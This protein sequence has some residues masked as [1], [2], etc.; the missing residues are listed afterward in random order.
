VDA[1]GLPGPYALQAMGVAL[2]PSSQHA[3]ND[4]S[5]SSG[6]DRTESAMFNLTK[7]SARL[8]EELEC[9]KR[10]HDWTKAHDLVAEEI[11]GETRTVDIDKATKM[12]KEQYQRAL[13]EVRAAAVGSSDHINADKLEVTAAWQERQAAATHQQMVA[14]AKEGRDMAWQEGNSQPP[15]SSRAEPL[16]DFGDALDSDFDPDWFLTDEQRRE[17]TARDHAVDRG[18]LE[19]PAPMMEPQPVGREP[20]YQIQPSPKP[21]RHK[22]PFRVIDE[23][24]EPDEIRDGEEAHNWYAYRRPPTYQEEHGTTVTGPSERIRREFAPPPRSGYS[25]TVSKRFGG[26]DDD[27]MLDESR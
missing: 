23:D 24:M 27:Y 6:R 15:G 9:Q 5:G 16:Q 21:V 1:K 19:R 4:V 17:V 8:R 11:E 22:A 13:G 7:R 3:L 25:G 12:L 14:R 10:A 18:S 26:Y 20:P 2:S